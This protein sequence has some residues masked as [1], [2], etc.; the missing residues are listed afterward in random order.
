MS[1][2]LRV[3]YFILIAVI[4]VA[5]LCQGLLLPIL[6]ISLEQMGVSSSLNGMNA[7]ALYIGSFAMTLVAE[8]TLGLLGFKS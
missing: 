2:S 3:H 5:G 1:S 4:I 8:R 6:S 7:A